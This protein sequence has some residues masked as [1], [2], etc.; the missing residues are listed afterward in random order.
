MVIVLMGVSG[1]GKTTVATL[2][3]RRL[4]WPFA[5][6]DALHPDAN[7]RK[8]AAGRPLSDA[9]RAPWLRLVADWVNARIDAGDNGLI[10]C[11]ALKRAYRDVINRRG[12]GVMFVF[13]SGSRGELEARLAAREDHFMPAELLASQLADLEPPAPDE[14]AIS[15]DTAAA[16]GTIA[17]EIVARLGLADR[18][19]P[20]S[21]G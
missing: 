16:P 2:L 14:P 7:V 9:D 4:G 21:H 12:S 13:L 11:S 19:E 10:T 1:S 8:M 5:E 17:D 20:T 3:H 15:V 6:G 18:A